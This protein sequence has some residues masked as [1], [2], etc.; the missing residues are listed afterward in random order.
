MR[1]LE[2]TI[3][4]AQDGTTQVQSPVDLPPGTHAA[5]LVVEEPVPARTPKPPFPVIDI[6]PWPTDL[7]LRREDMDGDD[8]R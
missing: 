8:G 6:G 3:T 7:S 4:V 2:V 5:V 1:A